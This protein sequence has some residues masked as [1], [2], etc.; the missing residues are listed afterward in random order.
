MKMLSPPTQPTPTPHPPPARAY[1]FITR[2]TVTVL[3]II[4]FQFCSHFRNF[5]ITLATQMQGY[6]AAVHRFSMI[7]FS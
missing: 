1:L 2:F 3:C 6:E 4:V 7:R 5:L